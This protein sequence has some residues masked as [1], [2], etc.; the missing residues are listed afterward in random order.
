MQYLEYNAAIKAVLKSTVK[1]AVY[2]D[3]YAAIK[4]MLKSIVKVAA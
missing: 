3:Y 1:V 2:V 4:A